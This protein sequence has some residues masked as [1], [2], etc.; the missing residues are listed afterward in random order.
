MR[1]QGVVLNNNQEKITL[2]IIVL[3]ILYG[4]MVTVYTIPL[5]NIFLHKK[6]T[7]YR[8]IVVVE[9]LTLLLCIRG[10]LRF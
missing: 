5:L 1:L 4:D 3:V 2:T 7:H 9:C 8:E 6:A 10:G